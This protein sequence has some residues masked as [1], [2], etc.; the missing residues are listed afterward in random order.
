M[1]LSEC[2]YGTLVFNKDYG[3]GMIKGVTNNCPCGDLEERKQVDSA[4]PLVEWADGRTFGFHAGN[5]NKFKG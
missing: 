2:T 5:L 1:K 4:I 3:V